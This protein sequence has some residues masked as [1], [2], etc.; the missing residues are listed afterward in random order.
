MA[1][2]ENEYR[3]SVTM[4]ADDWTPHVATWRTDD[5]GETGVYVTDVI[6][7]ARHVW[8]TLAAGR[9]PADLGC[10]LDGYREVV[11]SPV[12]NHRR[13][14][15]AGG[16][17]WHAEVQGTWEVRFADFGPKQPTIGGP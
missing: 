3:I 8:N 13:Y 6:G 17:Q 4:V 10:R 11:V 16:W 2:I 5:G 12:V 14:D 7:E 15:N 9:Q 1:T